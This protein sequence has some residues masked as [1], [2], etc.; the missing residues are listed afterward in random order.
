MPHLLEMRGITKHYP[1]VLALDGVNFDLQAGEVHCLVG[2]NGAGKS[3]LMKILSGAERRDV[4]DILLDGKPV[5]INS[6]AEAQHLGV[7]I[8]YQDFKLVPALSVA[9]NILLGHEPRMGRSPFIDRREMRRV[10]AAVLV[11][12]GEPIDVETPV[13]AL[14]VAHRQI[15]EIAK[16]IS[17]KARI[18]AMDEPSA[19]LTEKEL[20]KLFEVIHVLKKEEVGVIYISHR[21]E[22]IFE[23]GD[24]VTVLR[25]GE[26]INTCSIREADKRSL[27]RWMVGRE[28]ESEFPKVQLQRGQEILRV[29]G[30]T[31]GS[32][33]RGVNLSLYGGEIFGLAG[34]VGA[35]RSELARLIF[36]ADRPES[37][38]IYL[39]GKEIFPRSPRQ[40]ID[41]GIGLLTEDRNRYGLIAQMSVKENISLSN[42][43]FL[44]RGIFIDR[45]REKDVASKY[46]DQLSIKTPSIAQQVE[47][48]SGGNRQ[49][50]VLARWLFTK[51]KLLI[52]D[53]PTAGIDVGVKYEIYNIINE[54]GSQGMGVIV[55]SSQLPELLGI[56]DRI[57]VM[58]EG[59]VVG[60]LSREEANQEKIMTLATGGHLEE[61]SRPQERGTQ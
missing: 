48:L 47:Y 7:G 4:G 32:A 15:V 12:L 46:V 44:L 39:N 18:I 43:R 59:R 16:V 36:G 34:L 21:L 6:P 22:E 49:K 19:P 20:E 58:W 5:S 27:I 31:R 14:S 51:C 52:F 8:I 26:V 24:R 42:L 11:Q 33:V 13:E 3:T 45:K 17:R 9:E 60:I 25:D 30:L 37:G 23:I 38:R 56:C 53:E 55:I 28:I 61:R 54:L 10:S 35:G 2:E 41:L 1:G 50:V 29:E 40:A 57:G